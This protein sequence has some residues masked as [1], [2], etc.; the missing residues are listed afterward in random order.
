MSELISNPSDVQSFTT[1]IIWGYYLHN[2][3]TI[4]HQKKAD[5]DP[6]R[7]V[8]DFGIRAPAQPGVVLEG[9]PAKK[10]PMSDELST[11][12][13]KYTGNTCR[14]W[15]Q[16]QSDNMI[17]IETTIILIWIILYDWGNLSS[18]GVVLNA[19]RW[20]KVWFVKQISGFFGWVNHSS[21]FQV[22]ASNFEKEDPLQVPNMDR[23]RWIWWRNDCF[24]R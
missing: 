18:Y 11:T 14:I 19:Q 4:L 16:F 8:A 21:I 2:F 15:T 9:K 20:I 6:K 10:C 17:Q 13:Y 12:K 23:F 3:K 5:E 7:S 24:I 1:K 22:E